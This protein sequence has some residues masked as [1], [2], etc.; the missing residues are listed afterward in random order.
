MN[1]SLKQLRVFV[2][3][4][5]AGSFS[6]AGQRIGLS[7]SAVSHS[8]KELEET[9]GV[10]LL[11]RTTR[12]VTLTVAGQ[13][14]AVRLERV[15]D[16]LNNTLLDARSTGQQLSG[17]VRVAASQTLSAHLMP[18]SIACCQQRY[19]AIRFV[20][21]D[22]PQ[23][24]VMESIRSGE[25]DF[26]MVI[27]PIQATDLDGETVLAEP[28]LLLCRSDHPLA[29]Q[30]QVSWQALNGA[31]LVLQDYA[32]GSRALIDE[33]LACQGI[34]ASIVQQIGH[35]AT[36]FPMVEAGI[37]ISVLPALALPLPESRP[38]V[39]R[40][41]VPTVQRQLM[42]MRRKNRSL[43]GAARAVWEVVAEQARLLNEARKGDSLF[44]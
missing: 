6:R 5:R 24:W 30:E 14:L 25:V 3:V 22:R 29:A 41:L 37:G 43:S 21:H 35:P 42:L 44:E 27:D 13:Q 16:E 19:P 11:D 31:D 23:H 20:L 17:T 38:L 18:Q 39:V 8:I 36:L 1:Y 2:A 33:A 7:Q 28:F 40:K 10:R 34:E 15:L 9:L 12:E 32:S 4:A 26:G